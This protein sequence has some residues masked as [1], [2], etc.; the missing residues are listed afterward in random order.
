[1]D[2]EDDLT[3]VRNALHINMSL[4]LIIVQTLFLVGID[5]IKHKFGCQLI[6]ILLDYFLLATFSWMFVDGIELLIALKHV[7]KIDRIRLIAY[8]IYSY[9]FPLLVVFLSTILSTKT[10]Y[11]LSA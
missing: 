6:S 10:K 8:S 4:C 1:M 11:G 3:I 2:V 9:G 5:Q 7:F